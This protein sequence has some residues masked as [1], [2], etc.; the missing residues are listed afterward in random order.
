MCRTLAAPLFLPFIASGGG[1]QG[2][3]LPFAPGE[4][5]AASPQQQQAPANPQAAALLAPQVD[6]TKEELLNEVRQRKFKNED[7]VEAD[8]N[9]DPFRSFLSDFSAGPSIKTQYEIL[10]PKYSL[11]ELKLAMVVG[12][13][14]EAKTG[15]AIA[16]AR[17]VEPRAMFI[18]PTG[19]GS[20]VVRGQHLS[21]SDARVTRIEPDKGKVYVEIKED[22]GAGKSRMVERVLE[23]HQGELN[24]EAN[25]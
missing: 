18:D 1:D 7:F 12:P 19:M 22:L 15:H 3:P 8:T 24:A 9:R 16:G 20:S 21:K 25:Q 2:Q 4:S 6:Q 14:T 13:P 11:D 5:S 23:L 17:H 10:F